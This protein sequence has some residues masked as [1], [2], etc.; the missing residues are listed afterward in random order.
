MPSLRSGAPRAKPGSSAW[1]TNAE[2]PCDPALQHVFVG[3]NHQRHRPE[4][5]HGRDERARRTCAR[6][7]LD[8]QACGQRV[9]TLS[10]VLLGDVD[11]MESRGLEGVVDVPREFAGLV[12][13]GSSRS[14]AIAHQ[15]SHRLHQGLVLLAEREVSRLVGYQH[16]VHPSC[17][18]S[19]P[20]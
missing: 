13:I 10:A 3:R 20:P 8:H 17:A 5:V 7:L 6:H 16:A 11:G 19:L 15:V 4:L 12:D 9:A 1:T 18:A 2:I 14:D